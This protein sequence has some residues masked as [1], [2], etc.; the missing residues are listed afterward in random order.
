M[1]A[2]KHQVRASHEEEEEVETFMDS[3]KDFHDA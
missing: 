1:V 3:L 2:D